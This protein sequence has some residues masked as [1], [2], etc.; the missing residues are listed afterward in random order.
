MQTYT[1]NTNWWWQNLIEGFVH[2]WSIF[3]KIAVETSL[4]FRGFFIL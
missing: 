4:G 3:S 1:V 2:R